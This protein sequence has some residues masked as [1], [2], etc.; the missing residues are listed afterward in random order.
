MSIIYVPIPPSSDFPIRVDEGRGGGERHVARKRLLPTRV[1]P[2]AIF[3]LYVTVPLSPSPPP[4]PPR[5]RKCDEQARVGSRT[6][7][8][9]PTHPIISYH[10]T[11]LCI[12]SITVHELIPPPL[13]KPTQ[14]E[15]QYF[16]LSSVRFPPSS[17]FC[18]PF[19]VVEGK[20]RKKERGAKGEW[21]GRKK[22]PGGWLVALTD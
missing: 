2:R 5:L 9:I 15:I 6:E 22:V 3:C 13:P 11:S 7:H 10:G 16:R 17:C 18:L 12:T 4:P 20:E 14:R 21:K 19:C 8:Q 1:S